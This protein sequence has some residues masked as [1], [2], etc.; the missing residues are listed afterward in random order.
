MFFFTLSE[1][2][3]QIFVPMISLLLL[4]LPSAFNPS[5]VMRGLMLPDSLWYLGDKK[6]K[7][8][9][10]LNLSRVNSSLLELHC[11][12]LKEPIAIFGCNTKD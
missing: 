9:I 10:T 4:V 12:L 2:M 7:K 1:K 8:P 5:F 6:Q 11:A 3:K